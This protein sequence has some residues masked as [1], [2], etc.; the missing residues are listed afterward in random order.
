VKKVKHVSEIE[1]NFS[2]IYK[3]LWPQVYKFIY[4]KVQN[5]EEAE[6]LTQEVFQRVYRQ[7][8]RSSIGEDKIKAYTL[9]AARNIV[10]DAWKQRR[11]DSTII[12]LDEVSEKGFE[13]A[14][15]SRSIEDNLLVKQAL[16][17]LTDEDRNIV[18]LRIIKGYSISEVSKMLGKPEGTVKSLQFRALQKLREKLVKGGYFDE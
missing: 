3:S 16:R 13:V 1:N 4:Y 9:T 12:R 17:E 5:A 18:Q 7:F 8:T 6:E 14:E 2:E 10:Y 11:K 15:E